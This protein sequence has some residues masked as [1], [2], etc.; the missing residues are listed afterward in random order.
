MEST[1]QRV[2][3]GTEPPFSEMSLLIDSVIGA[4]IVVHRALGPGFIEGIYEN[5]LCLELN[6][7]GIPHVR[8]HEIKVTYDGQLVGLHRLD[9]L[10]AKSLIL[11]LKA[12][13]AFETRHFVV[14]RSYLR[15]TGLTHALLMNF[16][17]TTLSVKRVYPRPA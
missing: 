10:I 9:L 2:L 11:E 1:T 6:R 4:A 12:I 14:V 8:Q 3:P 13:D 16:V 15:A 5:A 17:G 7:C